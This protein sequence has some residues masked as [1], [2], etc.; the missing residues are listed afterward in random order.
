[1]TNFTNVSARAMLVSLQ[2]STWSAR[3]FDRR[4]SDE[5]NTDH[6]ADKDASRVN[7]HL[8]AG[9]AAH[10]DLLKRAGAARATHYGQTLPW[11]DDGWRLLPTANY[12]AYTEAMRKERS[13]FNL[14]LDSFLD[15]YPA[16]REQARLKLGTLYREEDFPTT[17]DV[18][19]RFSWAIEF[20][21]VPSGS[22]IRVDLP[23]DQ[24]AVIEQSVTDR[25]EQAAKAAMQD[26][27]AR[28]REAVAR[29]QKASGPDGIVRG[30]LIEH[31]QAIV[32]VL[33][34]LNVGEDADLEAM[35]QRVATELTSIAPEDLRKDE[36]LRA[37]TAKRATD[38]MSSM[39]AFY[40]PQEQEV[41]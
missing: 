32:D 9:A 30:N 31:A 15:E 26:A 3:K 21:P 34:R 17:S 12:M 5:V 23:A 18:S 20:S 35:R 8:L 13:T 29:I 19:G 33:G 16:L 41:A 2:I 36:R 1:M 25:V 40:A 37:D 39:S 11:A 22:D 7:K 28:L 24:I 14:A 38:I 4:V 10:A 27:W 6:A